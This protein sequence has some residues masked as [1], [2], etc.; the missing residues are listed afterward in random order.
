MGIWAARLLNLV[1]LDGSESYLG[2]CSFLAWLDDTHT[3]FLII[4]L[5]V[6]SFLGML[7]FR[8]MDRHELR[9]G[10]GHAQLANTECHGVGM[11]LGEASSLAAQT[12][13]RKGKRSYFL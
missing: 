6:S 10:Y 5:F 9:V 11:T 4:S 7:V 12:H 1:T 2:P 8:V 13:T 3:F